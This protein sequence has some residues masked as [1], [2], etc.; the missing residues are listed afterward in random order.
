MQCTPQCGN[1]SLSPYL[2]HSN[3][4]S[5]SQIYL[6][7][8]LIDCQ[9]RYRFQDKDDNSQQQKSE[10][11]NMVTNLLVLKNVDHDLPIQA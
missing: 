9:F 5:L 7:M 3:F 6:V 4:P 10:D 11:A 1:V 2:S 8:I